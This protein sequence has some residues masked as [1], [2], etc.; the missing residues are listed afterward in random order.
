MSKNIKKTKLEDILIE[1][2]KNNV[3][4]D[5]K[6]SY[7]QGI[8]V[9]GKKCRIEI[10]KNG[11]AKELVIKSDNLSVRFSIGT[12]ANIHDISETK[13]SYEIGFLGFGIMEISESEKEK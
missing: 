2:H 13:P 6:H 9:E 8:C 7:E 12:I 1:A 11:F 10:I 4:F 3:L 5:V